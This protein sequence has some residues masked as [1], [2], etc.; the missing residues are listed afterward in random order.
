MRFS[1]IGLDRIDQVAED[2]CIADHI[3]NGPGDILSGPESYSLFSNIVIP[4]ASSSVKQIHHAP[5]NTNP[6]KP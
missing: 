6:I 4:A 5:E 1:R 3:S 2:M